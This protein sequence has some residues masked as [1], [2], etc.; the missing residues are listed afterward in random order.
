VMSASSSIGPESFSGA[1]L[2][3]SLGMVQVTG[4]AGELDTARPRAGRSR[5]GPI[6]AGLDFLPGPSPRVK[7]PGSSSLSL[8][9]LAPE[10]PLRSVAPLSGVEARP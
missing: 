4:E 2:I 8:G 5:K 3:G 10:S 6:E 9:P 7:G 1:R